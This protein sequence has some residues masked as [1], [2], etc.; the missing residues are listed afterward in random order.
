MLAELSIKKGC[1]ISAQLIKTI[2][3]RMEIVGTQPDIRTV[4]TPLRI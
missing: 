3:V 4:F 1:L 2:K